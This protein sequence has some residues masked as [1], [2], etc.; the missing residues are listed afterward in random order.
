MEGVGNLRGQAADVVVT[1]FFLN[2]V[3]PKGEEQ[4]PRQQTTQKLTEAAWPRAGVSRIQTRPE[5]GHSQET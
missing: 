2:N 1:F 5:K 4:C 3:F